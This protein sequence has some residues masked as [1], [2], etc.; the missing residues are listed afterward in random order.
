MRTLF[1]LCFLSIGSC[2]L[3][4]QNT[5]KFSYHYEM[6]KMDSTFEQAVGACGE[7]HALEDFLAPKKDKLADKMN[8]VIGTAAK[9]LTLFTPQSPL[10]NLISD[11]LFEFG[12]HFLIDAKSGTAD[13]ALLNFGGIRVPIPAGNI[14]VGSVYATLPFDNRVVVISLKGSELKKV[15]KRFT[16][17]NCQPVANVQIDIR[18]QVP[19]SMKVNHAEIDNERIYKLVTIDFIQTGG[20]GILSNIQFESV[21]A[22]N[23]MIRDVL[24]QYIQAAT[25]RGEVIDA[26]IDNR[27]VIHP[28]F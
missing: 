22:T 27:I 2:F 1:L 6:V 10:S 26:A 12:N 8:V 16:E 25:K 18:A 4:A 7:S 23:T 28:Q 3:W 11:A 19:F 20:D 17:K 9:E 15:L 24:I 14:T 5:Q 21:S 13:L